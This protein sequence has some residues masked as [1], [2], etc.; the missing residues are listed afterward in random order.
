MP[1]QKEE[2]VTYYY[3]VTPSFKIIMILA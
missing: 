1:N 2:D 3:N